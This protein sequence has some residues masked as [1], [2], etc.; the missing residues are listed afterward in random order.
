VFQES[1]GG[2][3]PREQFTMVMLTYKR[4]EVLL[5]A[6]KRLSGLPY[7]NKVGCWSNGVNQLFSVETDSKVSS[8]RFCLIL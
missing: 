6:L 2:N 7:L 5:Q 4:E 8:R 1:L 3:T